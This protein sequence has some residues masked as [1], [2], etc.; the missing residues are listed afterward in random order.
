MW[1][2]TRRARLVLLALPVLLVLFVRGLDH[3]QYGHP[4]GYW[5]VP[6]TAALDEPAHLATGI[7]G[8]LALTELPWLLRHPAFLAGAAAG[9]VLIDLDHIALYEGVKGVDVG[10]R[11][12]THSLSTVVVLAVAG[13]LTRG[14]GRQL[15]LG[16]SLGVLLHLSRD[17]ATGPGVPLWWPFRVVGQ[18]MPY[19][20][21][22]DGLDVTAIIATCRLGWTL[23]RQVGAQTPA[24]REPAHASAGQTSAWEKLRQDQDG[25]G[26][27]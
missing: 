5:S 19:R 8:L 22:A 4:Y 1:L 27:R 11:P 15:L 14:R 10:G 21:Y 18:Q 25:V 26:P 23:W 3:F 20:W 17:I 9:S 13:L 16:L 12:F 24:Y 2:V 6:E 7:L